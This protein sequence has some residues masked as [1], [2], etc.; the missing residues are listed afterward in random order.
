[1]F[2]IFSVEIV[3]FCK[4]GDKTEAKLFSYI[5]AFINIIPSAQETPSF[6]FSYSEHN[7]KPILLPC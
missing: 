2:A 3:P 6:S 7:W 1:M 4:G 5:M